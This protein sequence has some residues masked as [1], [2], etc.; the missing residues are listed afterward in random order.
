MM[1]APQA[2]PAPS[3]APSS[4]PQAAVAPEANSGHVVTAPMVGTFYAAAAPDA[5]PFVKVG[6]TITVGQ[7][8]CIIE[9]MKLMN[10][11][12]SDVAGTVSEVLLQNGQPVGYGQ[13]LFLL[14]LG[15]FCLKNYN[16]SLVALFAIPSI[17][18]FVANHFSPDTQMK[19]KSSLAIKIWE[20]EPLTFAVNG[21]RGGMIL[22]VLAVA[23][24][25]AFYYIPM[26]LNNYVALRREYGDLA[27]TVKSNYDRLDIGLQNTNKI[28]ATEGE[29]NQAI[30]ESLIRKKIVTREQLEALKLRIYESN[31]A[32][33]ARH[34]NYYY[35]YH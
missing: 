32:K 11:L 1:A 29:T 24:L 35:G 18:F 19:D 26:S 30:I 16:P 4:V 6:D 25:Y 5:P 9:A 12:E 3:A 10:Q 14:G 7:P 33:D 27:E 8:L 15:L 17:A 34:R 22:W 21:M 31:A 23:V 20:F 28:L 2:A 13:A